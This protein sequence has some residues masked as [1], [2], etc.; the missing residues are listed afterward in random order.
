MI[1]TK[2]IEIKHKEML[3]LN[4]CLSEKRKIKN[5]KSEIKQQI[6]E[7]LKNI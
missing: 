6:A 5:L 7:S 3:K 1:L 2:G 4:T